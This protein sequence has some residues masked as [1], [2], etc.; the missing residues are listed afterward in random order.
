MYRKQGTTRR[1]KLSCFSR[2]SEVPQKFFHEY[3]HLSLIILNNE[4]LWQRQR[5]SISMKS[6]IGVKQQTFS[7]ANLSL[8]TV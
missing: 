3:K 2:F 7:P 5:E 6:L 8:S 4:Y 1:A